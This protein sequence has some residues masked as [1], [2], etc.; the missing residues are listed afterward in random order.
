MSRHSEAKA[1][2]LGSYFGQTRSGSYLNEW[3][4]SGSYLNKWREIHNS[5][6]DGQTD[7]TQHLNGQQKCIRYIC[8]SIR[9]KRCKL[10]F[11]DRSI[12][13]KKA[14]FFVWTCSL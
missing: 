7:S 5:T 4:R 11:L 3:E 13:G 10:C 12:K 6:L 8:L 9:D 2:L 1:T 14:F